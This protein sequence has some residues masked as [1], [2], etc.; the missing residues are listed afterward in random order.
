MLPER[1]IEKTKQD[2]VELHKRVLTDYLTRETIKKHSANSSVVQNMLSKMDAIFW[3][4]NI[5]ELK[6]NNSL[7]QNPAFGSGEDDSYQNTAKK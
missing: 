1:E 6:V 5:D 2:L 7:V 3:P 4:Y